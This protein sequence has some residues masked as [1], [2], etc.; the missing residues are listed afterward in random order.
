MD[1]RKA[2]VAR[3]PTANVFNEHTDENGATVLPAPLQAWVRGDR[4]EGLAEPY[5]WAHPGSG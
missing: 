4:V 5:R 1:N 2:K 3:K